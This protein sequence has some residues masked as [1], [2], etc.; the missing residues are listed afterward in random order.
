MTNEPDDAER[1]VAIL[2]R[3]DAKIVFAESCT[4]GLVAATLARIPGVSSY[5]CG[6]AV[7]YRDEVKTE[8]LGV[9]TQLIE[10]KSAVC[11]EVALEM[12][13]GV[14][15]STPSAS[16]SVAI[17]GHFG[18][19]APVGLDGIAYV[20]FAARGDGITVPPVEILHLQSQNRLERQVEATRK[21]LRVAAKWLESL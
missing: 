7:T 12:A 3:L 15:K 21:L 9:S 4:A 2:K 8:W 16:I 6:S 11:Q 13:V 20:G 18:P 10:K 19:H 17:T 5:L 1:L 14:L